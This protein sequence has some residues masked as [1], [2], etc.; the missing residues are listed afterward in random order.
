MKSPVWRVLQEPT[1]AF[2]HR[3]HQNEL[4]ERR[5]DTHFL[6]MTSRGLESKPSCVCYEGE[7]GCIGSHGEC[8]SRPAPRYIC[9]RQT[10]TACLSWL[11]TLV[12]AL[13]FERRVRMVCTAFF[14]FPVE[15]A[16]GD[17]RVSVTRVRLI[18]N[19]ST[20]IIPSA[21]RSPK[22]LLSQQIQPSSRTVFFVAGCFLMTRA[23]STARL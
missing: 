11:P 19:D 13:P 23:Y 12:E 15:C 20:R 17:A 22:G 2:E 21:P 10:Q 16:G 3:S 6:L 1:K 4:I 7:L 8:I 18:M 5:K 9:L 14:W